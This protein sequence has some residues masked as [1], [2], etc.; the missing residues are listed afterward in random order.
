MRVAIL[1]GDI[2]WET[3]TL[4]NHFPLYALATHL[5]TDIR[6]RKQGKSLP[7]VMKIVNRLT[8]STCQSLRQGKLVKPDMLIMKTVK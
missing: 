4:L 2:L 1:S 6:S 8:K 3:K 7:V 5:R